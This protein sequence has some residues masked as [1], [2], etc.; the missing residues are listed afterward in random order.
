MI[1]ALKPTTQSIWDASGTDDDLSSEL[2]TY[3]VDK[4]RLFIAIGSAPK[5]GELRQAARETWLRWIPDDASV[6]YRFF[7]DAKPD[8]LDSLTIDERLMWERIAKEKSEYDDIV[9][10]NL[11]GGYGD[12]E[13]NE[14][15]RRG[16]FQMK[17][18]L[19]HQRDATTTG[20][21]RISH[22]LRI[23]DDSFLCLHRLRYELP[24]LPR[25][26]FFWGRFWCKQG[27]NR[28]DENF[29]L[30]STDIVQVLTNDRLT[31]RLLPFDR[32][33]TL[34]WNFGYWSWILNLTIF[35]DQQR[36]DAQQ[37]YLTKYMHPHV[38]LSKNV[39]ARLSSSSETEAGSF[40][41]RFMFAHHVNAFAMRQA[42]NRGRTHVMYKLP[43]RRGPDKT[44]RPIDRS[45]LP[46]RHS[47][48]IPNLKLERANDVS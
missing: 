11:P 13:H 2:I 4:A 34:G 8:N 26:Q 6:T 29:M 39:A 32:D 21:S 3:E 40:C 22:F 7:T 48:L 18:V 33:V 14:Y 42:F 45:F 47:R 17:W 44:C 5:N 10:Q 23:D 19:H 9:E 37:G 28:A 12:N 43:S 1:Y 35:D 24:T 38:Q 30:F 36:I 27:R 31:G 46:A 20:K 25:A 41:D 15:G 16:I